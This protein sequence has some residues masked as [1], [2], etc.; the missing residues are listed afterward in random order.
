LN[1]YTTSGMATQ[2]CKAVGIVKFECSTESPTYYLHSVAKS[3][4]TCCSN[5][6]HYLSL[7]STN[8]LQERN[9]LSEL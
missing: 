6:F 3:R 4:H 5:L 7:H 9:E 1:N 8:S 2:L